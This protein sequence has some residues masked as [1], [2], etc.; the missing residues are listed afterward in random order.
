MTGKSNAPAAPDYTAAAAQQGT[1]NVEAAQTVAA[2]NRANQIT[3]LGSLTWDKGS[4]PY[5][6]QPGYD[7][8]L[9]KY[10]ADLQAY[11]GGGGTQQPGMG[12]LPGKGGGMTGATG[13][14]PTAPKYSDFQHTTGDPNAWTSTVTLSPNEQALLTGQEDLSKGMLQQAGTS[15][16]QVNQAMSGPLDENYIKSTAQQ[17]MSRQQPMFDRRLEQMQTQLANQGVSPGTQAWQNA[18]LDYNQQLNDAQNLAMQGAYGQAVS[19][20]ELPLSELNALRTGSQPS[21][22]SFGSTSAVG[23]IQAPDIMGAINS[24]YG[25]AVNSYNQKQ[26]GSN[27][28]MGGLFGLGSAFMGNPGGVMSLF[29]S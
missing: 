7:A 6:D 25:T 18:M 22:P 9:K 16:G 11:Q 8:A 12:N 15:L 2:I 3:P 19:Q 29:G 21:I 28:L 1:A 4:K 17:M 27:N 5:F 20:R 13:P 26:A 10:T 24:Q 23:G 14:S